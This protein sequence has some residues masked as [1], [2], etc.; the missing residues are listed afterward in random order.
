MPITKSGVKH[1]S[2]N[3]SKQWQ[4]TGSK[5]CNG[6]AGQLNSFATVDC[7]IGR[8]L[9]VTCVSCVYC[10]KCDE[11]RLSGGCHVIV[12]CSRRLIVSR[13]FQL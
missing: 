13:V 10:C 12:T 1:E 4:S 9:G 6:A 7:C 3:D 5:L 2:D 8:Q 11:R